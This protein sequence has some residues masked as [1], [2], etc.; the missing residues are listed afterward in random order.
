MSIYIIR[1]KDLSLHD[2][3]V[4]SC[5]D[6]RRRR[7][8]HKYDCNNDNRRHN[9]KLY[10]FIRANGGWDNWEMVEICKCENDKLREMEQY[11]ID[12]I[13]PSLNSYNAY[14]SEELNKQLR[15]EW[16][17]EYRRK[18]KE[19]IKEYAKEWRENNKDTIKKKK[20][21]YWTNNKYKIKEK[22]NEKFE[23]ECGGKYTRSN[24]VVHKRTIKHQNY[25]QSLSSS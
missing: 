17:I 2:C 1:S 5:D 6:I 11:H 25:I 13:K 12:F 9:Y 3:Y 19:H 10:Q 18:N 23:C 20:K 24:N 14:R 8:E 15:K 16:D 7:R 4:G 22:Q 21:E